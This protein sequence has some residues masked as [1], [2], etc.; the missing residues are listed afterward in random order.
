MMIRFYFAGF[1]VLLLMGFAGCQWAH[2][3]PMPAAG[4]IILGDPET[5][6]TETDSQYLSDRFEVP[7]S[8]PAASARSS[9]E[10]SSSP[11]STSSRSSEPQPGEWL[12]DVDGLKLR[13]RGIAV[14]GEG[15][16][17][18]L[19]ADSWGDPVLEVLEGE[20][21][22]MRQRYQT[23]VLLKPEMGQMYL[24][25]LKFLS[26]WETVP[27]TSPIQPFSILE[28]KRLEGA[29]FTRS[30]LQQSI[31][32]EGRRRNFS[33]SY[34]NQWIQAGIK[35]KNVHQAPLSPFLTTVMWQ[36]RGKNAQGQT[37]HRQVR[38]DR[39]Y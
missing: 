19:Q 36:I 20:L 38:I 35:A 8:S 28:K 7:G 27:T 11:A 39:P 23:I 18:L 1:W 13:I 15:Y 30:R 16:S 29:H 26:E 12:L 9:A 22:S 14:R 33:R 2:S 37:V 3:G 5:I 31:S 6:V 17:V 4:P 24:R 25:D 32:R 34:E 21:E 10:P